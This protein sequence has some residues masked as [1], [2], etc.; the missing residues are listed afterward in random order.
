[1][2]KYF[3]KSGFRTLSLILLLL[4]SAMAGCTKF[5]H[6]IAVGK[7]MPDFN[8]IQ[9]SGTNGKLT[10]LFKGEVVLVVFWATW[11]SHCREE[12]PRINELTAHYGSSLAVIGVSVGESVQTVKAHIIGLRIE[13]PVVVTE[14][15]DFTKLKIGSVPRLLLLDSKGHIRQIENRVSQSLRERI[16]QLVGENDSLEN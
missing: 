15:S 5:D 13:Y 1:M 10:S 9:L 16:Q 12:V 7:R 6:K 11:C 4:I 14:L 3:Q 8:V 2:M